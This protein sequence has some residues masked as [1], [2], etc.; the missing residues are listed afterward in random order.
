MAKPGSSG[1]M[2]RGSAPLTE[3]P[4]RL[5]DRVLGC[6]EATTSA[7]RRSRCSPGLAQQSAHGC[8]K[9]LQAARNDA[10]GTQLAAFRLQLAP[11]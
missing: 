10:G 1:R 2:K 8:A 11:P 6:H 9:A 3:N 7:Q 5:D 4:P